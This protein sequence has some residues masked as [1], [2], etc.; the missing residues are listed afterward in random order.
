M[1][2]HKGMYAL[3]RDLLKF[4][5]TGWISTAQALRLRANPQWLHGGTGFYSGQA[6]YLSMAVNSFWQ[7]CKM[8][9]IKTTADLSVDVKTVLTAQWLAWL[10]PLIWY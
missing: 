9:I 8:E 3:S 1:F 4:D 7:N 2:K 10:H 6:T 5:T